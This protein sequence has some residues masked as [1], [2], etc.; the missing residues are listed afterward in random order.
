MT[1]VSAILLGLLAVAAEGLA[2]AQA[3][4]VRQPVVVNGTPGD[5]AEFPFL[6]SLLTASR[7]ARDGAYDAQF[8]GGTLVSPTKVVT[9]AHCVVESPSG[10]VTF[11]RPQGAWSRIEA[12]TRTGD[13]EIRWQG[14]SRQ[15]GGAGTIVESGTPGAA[16]QIQ[17][18]SGDITLV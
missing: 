16:F 10:D 1:L 14:T 15:P 8:C 17:S 4:P 9:A 13:M 2:P 12:G 18:T 6:V 7:Y 5:P 11:E 3:A